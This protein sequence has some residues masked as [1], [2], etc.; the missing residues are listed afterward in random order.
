MVQ[1]K[2]SIF[3]FIP[4]YV[5]FLTTVQCTRAVNRNLLLGGPTRY[6]GGAQFTQQKLC[7]N[8]SE[9]VK[10]LGQKYRILRKIFN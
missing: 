9:N 8:F 2:K 7:K 3:L 10:K 1:L 5:Q 4:I 6:W